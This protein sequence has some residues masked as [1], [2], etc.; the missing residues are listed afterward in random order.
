MNKKF[1]F[2]FTFQIKSGIRKYFNRCC[3]SILFFAAFNSLTPAQQ[4]MNLNVLPDGLGLSNQLEYSYDIELK[5]QVLENWFNLDYSKGI[6]NSG[7]RFDIFEPNDPNPSISRG[8]EKYAK[9]GFVHFDINI[10]NQRESLNITAGNFYALI[11]RGM[12]LKSYE[13]RNIRIDN[14]LLGVMAVGKYAGFTLTTFS[15]MAEN[16][17]AERKD[18]LQLADIEYRNI[19]WLKIGGTYASNIPS[20][21]G[22]AKTDLVSFRLLP[23]LWNFDIYTEFG[24][25]MNKDIQLKSFNDKESI[26]GK[27]FYGNLNFYFGS[28]S[29]TG[30]YKYY[31]NFAF[32][33]HD[34]TVSYNTPPSVRLEYSYSLPNRHPSSLNPNNEE[35]FQVAADYTL[36]SE[37]F[38]STA[39]TQTKTLSAGSYYDRIDTIPSPPV[40]AQLKEFFFSAHRDWSSSLTTI[41]AIAYNEEL[42]SNTKN[43]TP[44]IEAHYYFKDVNTF[45]GI[46][47]HQQTTNNSNDEQHYTDVLSLEY[48]RSPGFSV[49]VVSELETKE[50]EA[51]HLVRKF[52]GFIQFGYKLG[53]HTDLSL[54][55]GSRQAGNI[56]IGGVCRYEPEFRGIE[57]KMITRL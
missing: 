49:A 12:I 48:L 30:E 4:E 56:C 40:A 29:F 45:K 53:Y 57:F 14:N 9:I 10:G 25:K 51:G 24:V 16:S 34:G 46:F 26:V 31:D 42:S 28:L 44:I 33:T 21:D 15:G 3:I 55:V 19:K 7:I 54:L 39:Y 11:G 27:G 23:G 50:P 20:V 41:T 43:I 1:L 47:E 18:I 38:I 52:F 35:G 37:T 17:M 8:K 22:E 36:D 2:I 5:R 6:F 32:T 13:D